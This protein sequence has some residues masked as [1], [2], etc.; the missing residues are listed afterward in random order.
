[1]NLI[2]QNQIEIPRT[3]LSCI[4]FHMEGGGGGGGTEKKL[5]DQTS[6]ALDQSYLEVTANVN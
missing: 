1:M 3:M 5:N 4:L 6:L 2:G